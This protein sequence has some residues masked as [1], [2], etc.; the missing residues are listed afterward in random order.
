MPQFT[1]ITPPPGRTAL[2]PS[3][4]GLGDAAAGALHPGGAGPNCHRSA[5]DF[6]V[7]IRQPARGNCQRARGTPDAN[8]LLRR[9][10]DFAQ[11]RAGGVITQGV[12][13]QALTALE[14]D[15]LGLDAVDRRMLCSIIAHY[16]GG[17][18]GLETLAATVGEEAVTLEDV[19]E[20]YLMQM[21]FLTRT[22]RGRCVTR[23]AYEHLGLPFHGQEQLKL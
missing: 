12:A 20:P 13:D 23:L 2:R 1:L 17:P 18:V 9:V 8:R 10:R 16:A 15:Q 7:P 3:A 14:V 21:G 19:Y 5:W 6:R 11:V 22:P 4:D